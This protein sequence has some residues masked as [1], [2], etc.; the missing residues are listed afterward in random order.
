MPVQPSFSCQAR[1]WA[2][3]SVLLTDCRRP[4]NPPVRRAPVRVTGRR[5][6]LLG[7]TGPTESVIRCLRRAVGSGSPKGSE[8]LF[9]MLASMGFSVSGCP[10]ETAAGIV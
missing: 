5:V 10:A 7:T 4:Q 9:G 2:R 3:V 1:Q 8:N 6:P